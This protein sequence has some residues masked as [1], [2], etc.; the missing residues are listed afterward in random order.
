MIGLAIVMGLIVF[1]YFATTLDITKADEGSQHED[2]EDKTIHLTN[3]PTPELKDTGEEL[4]EQWLS[5]FNQLLKE[6]NNNSED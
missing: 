4:K 3:I 2:E 6:S 1:V 5:E